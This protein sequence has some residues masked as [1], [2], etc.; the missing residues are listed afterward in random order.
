[1]IRL[2]WLAFGFSLFAS[3]TAIADGPKKQVDLLVEAE[4]CGERWRLEW[5]DKQR[6]PGF[7]EELFSS[8]SQSAE[9]EQ[10]DL[11]SEAY[12]LLADSEDAGEQLFRAWMSESDPIAAAQPLQR[13]FEIEP[14]KPFFLRS[15]GQFCLRGEYPFCD[16]IAERLATS[17]DM[18]ADG[19]ILAATLNIQSDQAGALK[20]FE[21]ASQ[22]QFSNN[23]GQQ[24]EI[25]WPLVKRLGPAASEYEEAV[26]VLGIIA[27]IS[28]SFNISP[29]CNPRFKDS[30]FKLDPL[31]CQ[32]LA[33]VMSERHPSLLG[34]QIG[35]E[36]GVE[37]AESS[38][39]TEEIEVARF[40]RRSLRDLTTRNLGLMCHRDN[41]L[42]AGYLQN[43]VNFG[44]VNTTLALIEQA[45]ANGFD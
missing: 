26:S 38:Q 9:E 13:V 33:R 19:L 28:G 11:L 15:L 4:K 23:L 21:Q 39:I 31:L 44:E 3:A 34:R 7:F 43:I 27:A 12:E 6:Y 8:D 18:T 37:L 32:D 17:P 42:P 45:E 1:M 30:S 22:R 5:Q 10:Y 41:Y 14:D 40:V 24:I 16:E 29:V 35:A 36:L 25:I 2:F 20:L